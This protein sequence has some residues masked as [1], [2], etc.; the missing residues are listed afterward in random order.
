MTFRVPRY[1]DMSNSCVISEPSCYQYS[2]SLAGNLEER[3]TVKNEIELECVWLGPVL[4]S[5]IDEMVS[6][7]FLGIFL[8]VLGMG[9]REDLRTKGVC[10]HERKVAESSNSDD[11][12]LLTRTASETDERGVS[13]QTST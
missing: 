9:N 8:L 11:T 12:D 13:C 5:G 2:R 10:P 4:V 6:T 7:E 3:L 1:V